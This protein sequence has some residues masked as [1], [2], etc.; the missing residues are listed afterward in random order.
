[1]SRLHRAWNSGPVPETA[2]THPRAARTRGSLAACVAAFVLVPALL[3]A[4]IVFRAESFAFSAPG[5]IAKID[6]DALKGEPSRLAW[7]PDGSQLY[8]QTLEGG[9]GRPNVTL[10]HYVFAVTGGARQDL[11]V[12]PE[13]AAEY[14]TGKSGRTSPD[15][16]AP[17]Q[18][19]LKSEKRKERT[20][21]LPMGGDLARGGTSPA[22]TENDELSILGAQAVGV[23]TMLLH[24]ETIGEFVN[25][26][27]VPGLT[28]G[29]A[30]EG[31]K[32]IAYAAQK[33]GRVVIMDGEGRKKEI[34]GSKDAI[35][36]AWSQDL[37][38]IAWLQ[39]D[40]RRAYLLRVAR[41]LVS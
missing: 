15:K 18:I 16:E 10:R 25:T 19:E 5:T 27:I 1:M 39:K 11:Q 28:Y 17:L 22:V 40:G 7:S 37:G 24:G 34:A 2:L 6:L 12:E 38:R 14:W 29:W 20:T 13:W 4:Q 8:V 9:F 36:P 35:L 30:P 21:S 26:V 32:L 41:V 33:S 3:D 31:T 23:H